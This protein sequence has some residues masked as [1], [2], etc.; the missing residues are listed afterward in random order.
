MNNTT[1][2]LD[3]KWRDEFI[4]AMRLND[5][6]GERIG[7]ALA[8]ADT[9]CAESGESAHAAFGPPTEYADSLVVPPRREGFGARFAGGI[10]LGL[11]GMLIVPRAVGAWVNGADVTVTD[12]NIVA[13]VVTLVLAGAIIFLPRRALLLLGKAKFAWIWLATILLIVALVLAQLLFRQDVAEISWIPVL[14]AGVA[15]LVINVTLTW[16]DLARPDAIQDPRSPRT[17]FRGVQW[18]TALSF[19]I[20]T[21]LIL[22]VD[23]VFRALN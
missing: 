17:P 4:L 19:P 16:R 13:L 3:D 7:D 12:G 11:M 23:A 9:H 2:H 21:L 1:S 14:L 5:A 20:G 18:I 10:L 15:L 6:S 22:G 8:T